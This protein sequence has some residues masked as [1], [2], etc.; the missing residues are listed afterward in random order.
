MP[1]FLLLSTL[2]GAIYGTIFH[3]WR[4]KNLRDLLIYLLAGVIGFLLG[5]AF[6]NW[7]ALNLMPIGQVH[8]VEATVIS[9]GCLL[10][11]HWLKI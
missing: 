11:I 3:L 1:P 4:G 7:I 6:S 10:L 5:Q 2:L 9:W 8:L